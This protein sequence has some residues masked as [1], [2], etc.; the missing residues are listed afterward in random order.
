MI[1]IS[2]SMSNR[3][4]RILVECF[5]GVGFPLALLGLSQCSSK[6]EAF[7]L[8]RHVLPKSIGFL[9]RTV[10]YVGILAGQALCA[11]LFWENGMEREIGSYEAKTRLP[12]LLRLVKAGQILRSPIAERLLRVCAK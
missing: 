6:P 1:K 10:G 5:G 12:E 7:P 9:K 3:P 4:V 11:F 2:S 8:E